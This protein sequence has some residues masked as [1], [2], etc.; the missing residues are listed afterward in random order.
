[1]AVTLSFL[2]VACGDNASPSPGGTAGTPSGTAGVE[3]HSPAT[4]PSEAGGS[5]PAASSGGLGDVAALPEVTDPTAV[6]A[7][8]LGVPLQPLDPD[9]AAIRDQLLNQLGDSVRGP[10]T[11]P[12]AFGQA[13][14]RLAASGSEDIGSAFLAISVLGVVMPSQPAAETAAS[15]VKEVGGQLGRDVPDGPKEDTTNEND[16]L[17]AG[18]GSDQVSGA[19]SMQVHV[20]QLRSQVTVDMTRGLQLL[21]TTPTGQRALNTTIQTTASVDFCPDPGGQVPVH[22]QSQYTLTDDT[23]T[24]RATIDGT[25][26]GQVDD[27]GSLASVTGSATLQGGTT[28]GGSTSDSYDLQVTGLGFGVSGGTVGGVTS[29]QFTGPADTQQL[30][31]DRMTVAK[32][33]LENSIPVIVAAAEKEFQDSACVIVEVPDYSFRAQPG[34]DNNPRK[35]VEASSRSTFQ[36]VVHHRFEHTDLSLPV[37]QRLQTE[38]AV[39]PQ[40]LGS[41]PGSATY[42]APNKR[43]VSN[44][45]DLRAWSRRGRSDLTI[46]FRTRNP[47]LKLSLSGTITEQA[48][49]AIV[50]GTIKVPVTEFTET[51]EGD[52]VEFEADVQVTVKVGLKI[53][54]V[55]LQCGSVAE[56]EHGTVHLQAKTVP[57]DDTHLVWQIHF[58]PNSPRFR[59]KSS[60]VIDVGNF[61]QGGAGFG[62]K[63]FTA[64]GDFQVPTEPGTTRVTGS[65]G[66]AGI[67]DSV[68]ARVTVYPTQ[69][70]AQ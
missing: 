46:E 10:V 59:S 48:A 58:F 44:D 8:Y 63:F 11:L 23:T 9:L 33:D 30:A 38:Q 41:T 67:T 36:V 22:V 56:T 53:Q 49:L 40:R 26:A 55:P 61:L 66:G 5:P 24:L 3:D 25:Y 68:S 2:L 69:D 70:T 6:L 34:S 14:A 35:W 17:A 54:G 28:S 29:G 7:G 19:Y 43:D 13:D 65:G 52:H 64:L 32:V 42:T 12:P 20:Q 57:K 37:E 27:T 50:T 31:D 21:R 18:S 47:P 51:A 4:A 62:S 15:I 45:D 39:D 16:P 1:M 60:C